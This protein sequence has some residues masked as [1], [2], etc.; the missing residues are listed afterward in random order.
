M[1]KFLILLFISVFVLSPQII[2]SADRSSQFDVNV[3]NKK[4]GKDYIV[5]KTKVTYTGR[6][7]IK[8]C[9]FYLVLL[10]NG[11]EVDVIRH[12]FGSFDPNQTKYIFPMFDYLG[13]WDSYRWDANVTY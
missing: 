9:S 7:P 11:K 4:I 8:A 12:L 5:V 10:N 13:P 6:K 2:H 3:I 1:R